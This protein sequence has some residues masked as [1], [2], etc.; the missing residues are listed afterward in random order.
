MLLQRPIFP[1]PTIVF[2]SVLILPS[3]SFGKK[4]EITSDPPGAEVRID[5]QYVG[6]TPLTLEARGG[7]VLGSKGARWKNPVTL[8]ISK[9]GCAA[10]RTAITHALLD[11]RNF[12]VELECYRSHLNAGFQFLLNEQFADS[13]REYERALALDPDQF[14]GAY[15][16]GVAYMRLAKYKDAKRTLDKAIKVRSD[17][18]EAYNIK[19]VAC[20][21][22]FQHEEAIS[23]FK[24]AL[25]LNPNF[26]LKDYN[27]AWQ[28]RL[29]GL[30]DE[31]VV[32][33]GKAI[34][35][36]PDLVEALSLKAG[37]LEDQGRI[38]EAVAAAQEAVNL[39]PTSAEANL[40]LSWELNEGGQPER[41]I[42][43][44]RKAAQLT[45]DLP[46]AFTYLCRV[47]NE[48]RNYVDALKACQDA[49]TRDPSDP[50]TIYYRAIAYERL[51]QTSNALTSYRQSVEAFQK[52]PEPNAYLFF[53]WGNDYY[54]LGRVARAVEKYK[55]AIQ[56]RPNFAPA[57][58]NI[59]VAYLRL[60]LREPAMEEYT[61]LKRIDSIRGEQ[62]QRFVKRQQADSTAAS[63]QGDGKS[64]GPSRS[65][66]SATLS[67][68]CDADCT[69]QI[70]SSWKQPLFAGRSQS[71]PLQPGK[72]IIS[73]IRAD[74]RENWQTTVVLERESQKSLAI[75]IG[76]KKLSP[77]EESQR[78]QLLAEIAHVRASLAKNQAQVAATE[79]ERAKILERSESRSE[80]RLELQ[81]RAEAIVNQIKTYEPQVEE[82]LTQAA[83][84]ENA[85]QRSLTQANA[86]SGQNSNSAALASLSGT[87]AYAMSK[88]SAEKHRQRANELLAE[89][90]K[91]SHE[92]YSLTKPQ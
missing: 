64:G 83:H 66:S 44:A 53:L 7:D 91:L 17:M 77:S 62:L 59:G 87:A 90:D 79:E 41:A 80:R 34:Q 67:L 19:G 58:L 4:L 81:R 16:L 46:K 69:I 2:L 73:A 5:E 78:E 49:L 43:Y 29:T 45:P 22:L 18:P 65:K 54:R 42:V 9:G 15:N 23:S 14:D 92:L 35:V 75:A 50:E 52:F 82:E 56:M 11:S 61:I 31:A 12:H 8:A 26:P 57:H 85:A 39:K 74:G 21:N 37:I 25:R 20:A 10:N 51:G 33:V 32:S 47:H 76:A 40:T 38:N 13:V 6:I 72:H 55:M 88:Q 84:D 68:T 86:T 63:A 60:G 70:D 48:L 30:L 28:Y 3:L 89:I 36:K 1:V 71:F 27:L 24:E